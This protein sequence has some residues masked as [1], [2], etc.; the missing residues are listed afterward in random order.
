MI[1]GTM[2][3]KRYSSGLST[4]VKPRKDGNST[5]LV[6]PRSVVITAPSALP[7]MAQGMTRK[8]SVAAKGMAPSVS[9]MAPMTMAFLP[10][11]CSSLLYFFGAIMEAIAMAQVGMEMA[12]QT[13][14]LT[15]KA[16]SVNAPSAKV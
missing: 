2:W 11:T 14:V 12:T 13:G 5:V 3:H 16:P 1:V 7:K 4:P 10:A 15:A 6:T 8:G 9:P